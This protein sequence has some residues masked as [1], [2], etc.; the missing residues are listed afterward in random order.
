MLDS[1]SFK[2]KSGR[3]YSFRVYVWENEFK[4]LAAVYVVTERVAEPDSNPN[5]KP[6]FVGTTDDLSQ[7]FN[8]HEKG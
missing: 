4:P 1:V 3:E 8:N 2:G 7:V 5:Y 6:V